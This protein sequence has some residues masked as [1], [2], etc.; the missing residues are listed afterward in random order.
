MAT[1]GAAMIHL[2]NETFVRKMLR[3]FDDLAYVRPAIWW[4]SKND[5]PNL[6]A[7]CIAV[8][9]YVEQSF[10]AAGGPVPRPMRVFYLD[11]RIPNDGL[12]D[13]HDPLIVAPK[14]IVPQVAETSRPERWNGQLADHVHR[15]C[16]S[17]IQTFMAPYGHEKHANAYHYTVPPFVAPRVVPWHGFGFG[18]GVA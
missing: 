14:S 12:F 6:L 7:P 9:G 16:D 8:V 5:V 4:C 10:Q 2:S 17:H 18:G 11:S 15:F 13:C 3:C 1:I